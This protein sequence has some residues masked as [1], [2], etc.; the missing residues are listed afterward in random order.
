MIGA[1]GN[2]AHGGSASNFF[3]LISLDTQEQFK[4]TTTQLTNTYAP[5]FINGESQFVAIGGDDGEGVEIWSVSDKKMVHHIKVQDSSQFVSCSYSSNG[6]LAVGFGAN[7]TDYLQLWEVHSWTMIYSKEYEM[8]PRSLFLTAD[9]KYLAAGGTA[10]SGGEKCII[11][12]I[13]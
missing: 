1:A 4:L 8:T 7:R 5:C 9:S 13:Q 12:E 11:L 6:I 10:Y 3:Y 2:V